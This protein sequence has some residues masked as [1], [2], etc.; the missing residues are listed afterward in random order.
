MALDWNVT[1]A[2]KR[3]ARGMRGKRRA[4]LRRRRAHFRRLRLEEL[5]QRRLLSRDA[6]AGGDVADTQLG[7]SLSSGLHRPRAQRRSLAI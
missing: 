1:G 7:S 4:D 5:E 2:K 3:S 6:L